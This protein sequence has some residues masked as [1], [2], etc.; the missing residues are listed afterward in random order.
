MLLEK[1]KKKEFNPQGTPMVPKGSD[2]HSVCGLAIL[3]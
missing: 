1:L 3:Q 2:F